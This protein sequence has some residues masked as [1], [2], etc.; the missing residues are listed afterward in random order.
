M[1]VETMTC[2]LG[3][4][5]LDERRGPLYLDGD[6]WEALFDALYVPTCSWC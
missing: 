2:L 5:G 4:L 6:A 1:S 3:L